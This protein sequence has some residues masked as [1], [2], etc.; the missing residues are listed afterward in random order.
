MKIRISP[1]CLSLSPKLSQTEY[2][3]VAKYDN[4]VKTVKDVS[5]LSVRRNV[6]MD[7]RA[8]VEALVNAK[9]ETPAK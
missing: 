1:S 4:S 7:T 6:V 5:F 3:S 9:A 8:A 2:C